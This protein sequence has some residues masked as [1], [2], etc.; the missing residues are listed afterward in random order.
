MT[1]SIYTLLVEAEQ[2]VSSHESDLYVPVNPVTTEIIKNYEFKCN[3]TRFKS[4]VDGRQMYEIPFAYNP[5]WVKK[6]F[7]NAN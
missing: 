4:N 7:K 6:G 5:F 2:E 3:V 1:K